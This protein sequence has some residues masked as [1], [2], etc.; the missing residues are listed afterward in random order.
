MNAHALLLLVL[1]A[2][3]LASAQSPQACPWLTAGTAGRIL[4][5][6]VQV[7]VKTD[8]NWSGYCIFATAAIPVRSIEIRVGKTHTHAC[9]GLASTPLAGIG[10]QAVLCSSRD[11][12]GREVRTVSG[13]VR[14]TWFAVTL[15]APST[16]GGPEPS[17]SES[18]ASPAIEFL[19]EQVAG[20][21]Y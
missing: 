20:N 8:S 19:A 5:G 13:H 11:S 14:D 2:P 18:T 12:S 21:L 1:L 3:A 17:T 6:E 9:G 4:G 10:N 16:P 15:A 7:T